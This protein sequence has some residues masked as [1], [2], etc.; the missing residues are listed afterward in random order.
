MNVLIAGIGNI[1]LGDDGFGVEVVRRLGQRELPGGVE[2]ID[3][4]IRGFDLANAL[5]DMEELADSHAVLVDA[6]PRG[7]EPGTLYLIEASVDDEV[8]RLETHGMDP[9]SVLRLVQALGGAAPRVLVVGCEPATLE[10]DPE[11]RFTLSPP[12][13][14]AV[15]EAIRMIES[16]VAELAGGAARREDECE[17]S[18]A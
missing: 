13:H 3:F 15:D 17:R 16:L 9:A 4:G 1:F 12:V 2:V 7:G 8:P 5:L 11:G 14:G 6:T 18:E 10:A